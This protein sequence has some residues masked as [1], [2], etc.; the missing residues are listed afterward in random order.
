MP[1]LGVGHTGREHF[2][3]LEFLE[4]HQRVLVPCHLVKNKQAARVTV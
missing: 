4:T 3:S 2:P 1:V